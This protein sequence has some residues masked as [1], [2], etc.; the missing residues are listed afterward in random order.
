MSTKDQ[1]QSDKRVYA[2]SAAYSNG[3]TRFTHIPSSAKATDL[4]THT[5]PYSERGP[6]RRRVGWTQS[7]YATLR[8]ESAPNDGRRVDTFSPI[9]PQSTGRLIGAEE[10]ESIMR[11]SRN[12]ME[13]E[14]RALKAQLEARINKVSVCGSLLPSFGVAVVSI[15]LF[16]SLSSFCTVAG[17]ALRNRVKQ[18][19]EKIETKAVWAEK[20][21]AT[22]SEETITVHATESSNS[23]MH[24]GLVPQSG[25]VSLSTGSAVGQDLLL[26]LQTVEQHHD[27]VIQKYK[28]ARLFD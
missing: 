20:R 26:P 9:S 23:S 15:V 13:Q 17:H 10:I 8:P 18:L 4:R 2:G 16:L 27:E 28:K 1:T 14:T 12:K 21:Q 11:E 7:E 19:D 24:Q 5:A 3:S 22:S 6:A 25:T